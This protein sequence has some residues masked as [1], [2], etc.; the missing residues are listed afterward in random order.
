VT[1]RPIFHGR[2]EEDMELETLFIAE[3]GSNQGELTF[4]ATLP[5]ACVSA[6]FEI[7]TCQRT[8]VIGKNAHADLQ[9][10][11][12][13]RRYFEGVDAYEFLLRFASGLESEIKGETDVFGQVK[14]AFKNLTVQNPK[15]AD[16]LQSIFLKIFEDTKEIRTQ[17]LQGIG[18]S[19]YGALA[20]RLLNPI[21]S[22]KVLILGAGQISKS[23]APYFTDSQKLS[24]WNRSLGRLVSLAD[25]LASKGHKEVSLLQNQAELDAA[26]ME[27]TIVILATPA[28]SEMDVLVLAECVRSGSKKKILHLGGQ[29]TDL[30][31]FENYS[32]FTSLTDLFLIEKEQTD[33]RKKQVMQAM[34]AC[35]HRS[36]LRGMAKSIHI[37][38]G[39]GDLALFS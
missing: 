27:A 39:W 11:L 15:L 2:L 16:E 33:L 14:T 10:M 12:Q 32:S 28:G 19:T 29:I 1:I 38:H 36:I 24:I 34:D 5:P 23:V 4:K 35:H 17:Y 25:E 22:E 20:R 6:I 30:K 3:F 13:P 26:L 9:L 37:S 21:A 8:L 7:R 31:L 18:G